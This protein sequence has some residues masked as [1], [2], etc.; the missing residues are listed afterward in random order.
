[1]AKSIISKIFSTTFLLVLMI[2]ISHTAESALLTAD[3]T[4]ADVGHNGNIVKVK[5]TH[6]SVAKKGEGLARVH[7]EGV[8]VGKHGSIA[9]VGDANVFVAQKGHGIVD[10]HHDDIDVGKDGSIAHVE[11][12][13]ISVGKHGH[14]TVDLGK[15][16]AHALR[17]N[18]H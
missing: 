17:G 5:P 13:E 6:I 8:N 16:Q 2:M 3:I 4:K 11:K 7:T 9:K 12:N 10:V 1:M 14:P 15:V 18:H